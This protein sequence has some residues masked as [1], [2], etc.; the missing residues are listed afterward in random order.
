[1][2]LAQLSEPDFA[3]DDYLYQLV[4]DRAGVLLHDAAEQVQVAAITFRIAGRPF[5][6]VAE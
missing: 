2:A 5:G 1:M 3:G 4:R 6:H